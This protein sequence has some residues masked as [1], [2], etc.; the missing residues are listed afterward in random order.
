MY[1][2]QFEEWWKNYRDSKEI[3]SYP[4]MEE[5]S[6]WWMDKVNSRNNVIYHFLRSKTV[7]LQGDLPMVHAEYLEDIKKIV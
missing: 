5:I 7:V 3:N 4:S 6:Q 1:E 2:K